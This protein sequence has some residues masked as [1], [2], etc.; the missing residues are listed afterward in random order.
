M[1]NQHPSLQFLILLLF[2]M[3]AIVSNAQV[4]I[5]DNPNTINANSLL[6]MESTN[7]G[8][9]P[10][11]VAINSL[12]SVAPLTGT[13]PAGMLVYSSGGSVADGYYYWNGNSW[14]SVGKS[15]IAT[16]TANASLNKSETFV[17]GSNDIILTLPIVT[18]ADNGLTVTVKNVGTYT[19]L[20]VVKGNGSA[21]IDGIDSSSLTRWFSRTYVAHNGNWITK[22]KETGL[23]NILD[24]SPTG[25]WTTIEEA[26][27]FLSEHM[28]GP[29]VIRLSGGTYEIATTQIID[30]DYPLTIQGTSFG[31]T[32]IS[33]ASGLSGPLF[34]AQTESY[35][36][37][38]AFDGTAVPGYA[39]TSGND[40]IQMEGSGEYYEV[41]DCNFDGFNKG[42]A[43]ETNTEAWVF[44]VDFYNCV[45]SGITVA[46][47]VSGVTLKVSEVDFISCAKGIHLSSGS[48]GTV[49]ILNSTFYNASGG[50][51]V[52]YDP[53]NFTSFSSIFITNN[54]WNGVGSF[55]NGFDFSRT[56]GRDAK[57]FLQ[58]N[59]GDPDRNPSCYINVQNNATNGTLTNA[60]TWYKANWNHTVT[61]TSTTKW[62]VANSSGNVNRITFQP[63]NKRSGYF[64]ITG[65]LSCNNS[66][67]TISISVFKS[68]NTAIRFGESTVRT[69]S[70]S[71]PT[72]FSF[73]A[74][75]PELSNGDYFEIGLSSTNGGDVITIQ[76]LQWIVDTK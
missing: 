32:I 27:E 66:N 48:N 34:R 5:G 50:I 23:A 65:S 75:I 16:K 22:E 38:I 33:P 11:R 49:S 51:G 55:F 45:A 9:L 59:A 1:K 36:K 57:A 35:F 76:D 19:D 63:V 40:A 24:V 26:I 8:I 53:T 43:I 54:A 68:G 73:I 70:A 41:K 7:K 20:V 42:I 64:I 17:L 28:N 47:S 61:S 72:P 25:S 44:E 56:D 15:N 69:G 60:N 29:S 52:D 37:M 46:S 6:E 74:F 4:K 39:N 3:T 62:T 10:P 67:R 14:N 30:L 18:S 2:L 13:V 21:T 71:T 12:T 58:N 31:K